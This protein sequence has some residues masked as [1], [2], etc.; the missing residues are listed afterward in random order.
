MDVGRSIREVFTFASLSLPAIGTVAT[1][2]VGQAEPKTSP[3]A[4]L[5]L[6][7]A[8]ETDVMAVLNKHFKGLAKI[9]PCA[10]NTVRQQYQYSALF[11]ELREIL[12]LDAGMYFKL[13]ANGALSIYG[14]INW[15]TVGNQG[16]LQAQIAAGK[17]QPVSGVKLSASYY[18]FKAHVEATPPNERILHHLMGGRSVLAK[19]LSREP[20]YANFSEVVRL[21]EYLFVEENRSN[22]FWGRL[23]DAECAHYSAVYSRPEEER[24]KP[25]TLQELEAEAKLI[26][27]ARQE[28]GKELVLHRPVI[29]IASSFLTVR[30]GIGALPDKVAVL[31][32]YPRSAETIKV[33][34]AE[35]VQQKLIG[36]LVLKPHID[37]VLDGKYPHHWCLV[38]NGEEI[39]R[40]ALAYKQGS[41]TLQ[42]HYS[43]LILKRLEISGGTVSCS[44]IK[45]GNTIAVTITK[46]GSPSKIM[47]SAEVDTDGAKVTEGRLIQKDEAVKFPSPDE[48]H[49]EALR[50]IRTTPYEGSGL[51][52]NLVGVFEPWADFVLQYPRSNQTLLMPIKESRLRLASILEALEERQ[53]DP[54]LK[55]AAGQ[56]VIIALVGSGTGRRM[57]EIPYIV[58]KT[59][60][61]I[62]IT[63]VAS[64]TVA[65]DYDYLP[66]SRE[67]IWRILDHAS[68]LEELVQP[69]PER[70]GIPS[71]SKFNKRDFTLGHV[72]ALDRLVPGIYEQGFIQRVHTPVVQI[73]P[74]D[75]KRG[76]PK[77]TRIN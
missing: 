60:L 9:E 75:L 5:V 13:D 48:V 47:L 15:D 49:Q 39:R 58:Q 20:E 62:P 36:N 51:L 35:R 18:R 59:K 25:T 19:N 65:L 71:P 11:E 45:G 46:E 21:S 38:N 1:E 77:V 22:S 26:V 33:L 14:R 29:S 72:M 40:L 56:S 66:G 55:L 27:R 68:I 8:L 16:L 54:K 42:A 6:K 73:G 31:P 17:D 23:R 37:A 67:G 4:P 52:I 76:W 28:I 12:K 50:L 63:F 30:A 34:E 74:A 7:A 44:A 57:R 3:S 32:D 41:K 69:G 43:E 61:S 64:D 70:A 53:K 24:D 10:A 2:Q